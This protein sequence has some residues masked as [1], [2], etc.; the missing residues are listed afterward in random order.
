[1]FESEQ[2]SHWQVRFEPDGSKVCQFNDQAAFQHGEIP[3]PPVS[4][5]CLSCLEAAAFSVLSLELALLCVVD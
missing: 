5:G 2:I 4:L 3:R 1:M